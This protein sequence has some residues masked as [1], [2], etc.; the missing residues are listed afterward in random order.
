M[1]SETKFTPGPWRVEE[2]RSDRVRIV[3]VGPDM[4]ICKRVVRAGYVQTEARA[5]AHL[6][7]AAPDMHEALEACAA[8]LP[9][10]HMAGKTTGEDEEHSAVLNRVIEALNP[11]PETGISIGEKQ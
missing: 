10:Y 4:E 6:I 8:I 7:A 1:M 5:N 3:V 2:T 9:R 11:L